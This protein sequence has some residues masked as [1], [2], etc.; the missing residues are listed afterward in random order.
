MQFTPRQLQTAL[1]MA[2]Q[3]EREATAERLAIDRLVAHG[4]PKTVTKL[5]ND[6]RSDR[7]WRQR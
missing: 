7:I 2:R 4:D 6:L 1:L 3:Q 5:A